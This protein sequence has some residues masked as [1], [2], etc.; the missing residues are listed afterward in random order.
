M[1]ERYTVE[2][3]LRLAAEPGEAL[4][5]PTGDD[6][7]FEDFSDDFAPW[8]IFYGPIGGE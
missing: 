8:V 1:S 5:M 7:R 2:Q 4:V 3:A 6:H